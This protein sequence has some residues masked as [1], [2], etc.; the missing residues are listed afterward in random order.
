MREF[1]VARPVAWFWLGLA[2]ICLP[3]ALFRLATGR[4]PQVAQAAVAMLVL[5]GLLG[6][7]GLR[8]LRGDDALRL[9]NEGL[10]GA[11]RHF[12]PLI[13]GPRTR[14]CVG[15]LEQVYEVGWSV[16]CAE[17]GGGQRLY[18]TDTYEG[19]D[20]LVALLGHGLGMS[21]KWN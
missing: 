19:H 9:S 20:E 15:D 12:G 14:I 21:G 6:W 16:W 8:T 3:T 17:D 11:T 7:R 5:C 4:D 18:W 1:D 13:F 10:E 2:S